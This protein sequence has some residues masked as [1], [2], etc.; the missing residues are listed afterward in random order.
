MCYST[1]NL[2]LIDLPDLCTSPYHH[3]GEWYWRVD[4]TFMAWAT[5][6][7][8]RARSAGKLDATT[9]DAFHR[10]AALAATWPKSTNAAIESRSAS[11]VNLPPIPREMF[12]QPFLTLIGIEPWKSFE[13]D[14]AKFHP[15]VS[16]D[17]PQDTR[18]TRQS[19]PETSASPDV[20]RRPKPKPKEFKSAPVKRKKI[21]KPTSQRSFV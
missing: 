21:E 17:P 16:F 12:S 7:V 10:L 3:A 2:S 18:P 4:E 19:V 11:V 20:V 15:G 1:R 9:A 6:A 5:R 13:T 8:T 14:K